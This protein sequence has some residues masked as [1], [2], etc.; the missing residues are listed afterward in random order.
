MPGLILLCISDQPPPS[1]SAHVLTRQSTARLLVAALGKTQGLELL[2]LWKVISSPL[3]AGCTPGT[4]GE[5]NRKTGV[6]PGSLLYVA[7]PSSFS[8]VC[9]RSE[10]VYYIK[11]EPSWGRWGDGQ[12]CVAGGTLRNQTSNKRYNFKKCLYSV[13]KFL[14]LERILSVP[15][16]LERF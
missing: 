6:P 4:P 12:N 10:A 7:L 13:M 16:T 5:R 14:F 8:T 9:G 11:V 3:V 2:H 15:Q 1:S